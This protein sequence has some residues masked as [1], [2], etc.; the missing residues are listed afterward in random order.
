MTKKQN[1]IY[2]FGGL[3]IGII[4]GIGGTAF[5]MGEEKQR[6]NNTLISHTSEISAM[7]LNNEMDKKV[8]RQESY[9]FSVIIASK[10]TQLKISITELTVTVGDLRTDVSVL[11]ALMF[12]VENDI[13]ARANTD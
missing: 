12:R 5:S 13:K 3:I 2:V 11:K 6:I 1:T 8:A 4:G 7:K 9:R 10:M